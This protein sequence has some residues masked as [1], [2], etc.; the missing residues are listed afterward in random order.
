MILAAKVAL[1]AFIAFFGNAIRKTDERN[2]EGFYMQKLLLAAALLSLVGCQAA[3]PKADPSVE[4]CRQNLMS[5]LKAPAS[6]KEV[7]VNSYTK[8]I[9]YEEMLST[10]VPA[11]LGP[12]AAQAV[13][14]LRGKKLEETSVFIRYDAVNEYNAPI[15]KLEQCEFLLADGKRY[16][17]EPPSKITPDAH[18]LVQKRNANALA[19]AG[20][21]ESTI[22][23][24]LVERVECCLPWGMIDFLA[25]DRPKSREELAADA[26]DA[27][28]WN[29]AM[30]KATKPAEAVVERADDA[31]EPDG[32]ALGDGDVEAGQSTEDSNEVS[33]Y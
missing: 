12:A 25:K 2:T 17:T 3:G 24:P 11:I 21:L 1:M 26:A 15:R 16:E 18:A 9:S 8:P 29:K 22:N 23:E 7:E 13:L 19:N 33:D 30:E 32:D 14:N 5:R 31:G 28:A 27:A 20:S 4:D 10:L 6:Y